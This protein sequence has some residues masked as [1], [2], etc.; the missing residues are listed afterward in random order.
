LVIDI[1]QIVSFKVCFSMLKNDKMKYFLTKTIL[2]SF[3]VIFAANVATTVAQ[4]FN[5]YPSTFYSINAVAS[6]AGII[7]PQYQRYVY[8]KGKRGTV[9]MDELGGSSQRKTGSEK[10]LLSA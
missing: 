2:I 1:W 4:I 10:Q 9:A 8:R 6:I 7:W 3:V 5:F